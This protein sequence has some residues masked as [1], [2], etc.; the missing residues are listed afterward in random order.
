MIATAGFS[1]LPG[2]ILLNASIQDIEEYYDTLF[3][4]TR[5][6]NVIFPDGTAKFFGQEDGLDMQ[7]LR[8]IEACKK[9]KGRHLVAS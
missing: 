2:S 8:Y 1:D 6:L 9:D 4:A 7:R 3:L 5:G